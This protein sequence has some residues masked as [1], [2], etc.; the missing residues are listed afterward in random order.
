MTSIAQ[1]LIHVL[2]TAQELHDITHTIV[3]ADPEI[4]GAYDEGIDTDE[5]TSFTIDVEHDYDEILFQPETAVLP[6][7]VRRT[8]LLWAHQAHVS[9]HEK[10]T[11]VPQLRAF[12]DAFGALCAALA[13]KAPI[14]GSPLSSLSLSIYGAH[15]APCLLFSL[16]HILL[17]AEK[18]GLV[19]PLPVGYASLPQH[20][21]NIVDVLAY[22]QKPTAFFQYQS[23]H[24]AIPAANEAEA[25]LFRA[26]LRDLDACADPHSLP[27]HEN[28]LKIA[29]YATITQQ[30]IAFMA[31]LNAQ[32]KG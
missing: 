11:F 24:M 32:K 2:H 19:T 25:S 29:S 7:R 4:E 28:M 20:L 22:L 17:N 12:E 9:A 8:G 30:R 13:E 6:L 23:D 21:E 14:L 18:T 16:N 10:L 27:P 1:H 15:A 5:P 3:K 26:F 31:R